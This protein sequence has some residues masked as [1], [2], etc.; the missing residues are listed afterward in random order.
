MV[1]QEKASYHFL[2]PLDT[3]GVRGRY[4]AEPQLLV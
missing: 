1:E 2:R 3:A 4:A